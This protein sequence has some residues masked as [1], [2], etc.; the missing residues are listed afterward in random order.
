MTA[1]APTV[2]EIAGDF[3]LD[4]SKSCAISQCSE[5]ALAEGKN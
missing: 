2:S 4:M 3:V 1:D 5:K